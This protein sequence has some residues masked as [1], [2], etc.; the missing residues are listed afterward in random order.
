MWSCQVA[1]GWETEAALPVH[2]GCQPWV[3]TALSLG[4][5]ATNSGFYMSA[6][7][8]GDSASLPSAK[9]LNSWEENLAGAACISRDG[10]HCMQQV[11]RVLK[12]TSGYKVGTLKK[13]KCSLRTWSPNT[14]GSGELGD[15]WLAGGFVRPLCSLWLP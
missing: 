5:N 2:Q 4:L 15:I 9:N 1:P 10:K 14:V 12:S 7:V 3:P 13:K 6:Y 8:Y 11:T